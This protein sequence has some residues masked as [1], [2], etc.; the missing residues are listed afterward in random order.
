M[1]DYKPR[2]II[3]QGQAPCTR[4]QPSHRL[5]IKAKPIS[6]GQGTDQCD[7]GYRPHLTADLEADLHPVELSGLEELGGL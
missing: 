3:A 6:V 4:M 5:T 2:P 7:Q 1:R